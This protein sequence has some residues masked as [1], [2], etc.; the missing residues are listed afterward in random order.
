MN[1]ESIGWNTLLASAVLIAVAGLT[2]CATTPQTSPADRLAKYDGQH[3]DVMVDRFGAPD[4]SHS[5]TNGT[6]YHWVFEHRDNLTDM[7]AYSYDYRY[8][9]EVITTTDPQD[10]VVSTKTRSTDNH[11][12]IDACTAMIK[13][14]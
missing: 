7:G 6:I 1:I 8:K 9:C 5:S 4:K 10:V 13:E 11:P 3:V 2:G 14:S 12:Y